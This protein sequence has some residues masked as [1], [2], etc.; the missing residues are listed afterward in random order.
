MRL[1]FRLRILLLF[2]IITIVPFAFFFYFSWRAEREALKQQLEYHLVIMANNL[3]ESTYQFVNERL[4]DL[5]FMTLSV[6]WTSSPYILRKYLQ[7]FNESYPQYD[8]AIYVN[9][10]GQV[11]A[12]SNISAEGK[13]VSSRPWFKPALQGQYYFSDIYYSPIV[14]R[15]LLVLAAPVKSQNQ[16]VGVVSPSVH[17]AN[18]WQM[19]DAFSSRQQTFGQAGYAFIIN[20]KGEFIAHPDR[21]KILKDNF[22]TEHQLQLNTILTA[23]R[24]KKLINLP[25]DRAVAAFALVKPFSSNTRAWVVGVT[26]PEQVL[27][28]PLDKLTRDLVSLFAVVLCVSL[29]FSLYLAHSLGQPLTKLLTAIAS[30]GEG[31][32]PE[33]LPVE[34]DDEIGKLNRAFNQ[35][36]WQLEEREKELIRSEKFKTA[37]QLAAGM[38]HEIRN[39]LTTIKGFLQIFSQQNASTNQINPKYLHLIINEVERIERIINEFLYISK[40]VKKES[41]NLNS[42]LQDL[43]MFCE[44]RAFQ[45]K[46]ILQREL[47]DNLPLVELVPEQVKQVFL[48]LIQNALESMPAGGELKISSQWL[49]DANLI[50]VKVSD[51]GF[52]MTEKTLAQLGTPFFTTKPD[53]HGLGLMLTYQLVELWGG[54]IQVKSA[55]GQGSTFSIFIPCSQ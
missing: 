55:P 7:D 22:L 53:G 19:V 42:L 9:P 1:N 2:L 37:G 31:K 47:A 40:S 32:K 41:V 45:Q 5:K 44:P 10:A 13:D 18:L 15:P 16:I 50:E 12:D 29:F 35:M 33:P 43:L 54:K 3:A 26:I 11:L 52:G 36:V 8:G 49:P 23:A 4:T 14:Q 6:P 38:A 21:Q 39:P 46:V 48:N 51:T 30:Y 28:A 34:S 20:Q 17:L 24:E 27:Y 25:R